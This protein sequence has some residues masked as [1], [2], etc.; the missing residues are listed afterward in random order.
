[1]DQELD[2]K[3]YA[4]FVVSIII[5]G[6]NFIAVSMSNQELPPLFGATLRFALASLLF[7]LIARFMGL[8]RATGRS[9]AGAAVYGILG[10]GAAYALLYYALVGLP[11]GTAAVILAA[12]PL[13]TLLI[14]A[15]LGQE[16]LSVRGVVGGA[17]AIGGIVI[18]SLDSFSGGLSSS[19]LIAAILATAV[20]AASSVVAKAL[21]DVHPVN[22]NAIGMGTGTLLLAVSSFAFGESWFLPRETQTIASISWLVI[23]GSVALFQLFLYVIKRWT[24][25]ATV[26]AVAGMPVVAVALGAIMLDQ[27]IT[28]EVLIG[29][30][31]VLAAVYVGAISGRKA[32][33]GVSLPEDA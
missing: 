4:A 9:A 14:A 16:R 3:T 23:F 15:L 26:Y 17:L 1:M 6:A 28:V 30:A 20:V 19:Y 18:L 12:V 33:P 25:S 2:S 29:G 31:M 8:P 5:G 27:P 21:P 24:A 13:V 10:F 22:M 7:L 32:A 11:A